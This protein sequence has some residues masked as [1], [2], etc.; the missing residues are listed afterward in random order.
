MIDNRYEVTHY[1]DSGS[2][3][4]VYEVFDHTQQ[5]TVALKLLDPALITG[6]PWEE[7]A[8]LTALRS[9]YILPVW[10]ADIFG[11]VPYIVAEL[12]QGS[13]DGAAPTA[14]GQAIRYIREACRGVARTHDDAILHRDIKLANLFLSVNDRVLVGDFGL[15]FPMDANGEAPGAGTPLTTAPEILIGGGKTSVASDVYSLGA[16][17]Y[18]L[19]TGFY[20]YND[21]APPGTPAL[22][23]LVA[24]GPPTPL[25]DLAPHVSL[26]LA[27]RVDRAL[28]RNA[29]DRYP[30]AAAFE[31]ELG[32]LAAPARLWRRVVSHPGHDRCWE[33]AG[34]AGLR[35]CATQIAGTN[36]FSVETARL[37]SGLRIIANCK[38]GVTTAALPGTLRAIFQRLGN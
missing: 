16:C 33:S 13:L 5:Q 10:N 2:Y 35:V 20:P 18:A 12:A 34:P 15:A 21:H 17:L 38:P 22:Q 26:G 9:E 24:A 6:W 36:R 11:G 37:V 14:P 30:S 4:E 3:G 32:H 25:R 31:A 23:A 8:R 27:G 19:L 7:A 29:A 28:A 1:I